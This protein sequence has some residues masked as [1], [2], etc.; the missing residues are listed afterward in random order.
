MPLLA[1]VPS[2]TSEGVCPDPDTCAWFKAW[3]ASQQAPEFAAASPESA[4][5][6]HM[7]H[8]AHVHLAQQPW[9]DASAIIRDYMVAVT[10]KDCCVMIA[11]QHTRPLPPCDC[12]VSA[13]AAALA[14][15]APGSAPNVPRTRE[16]EP[17]EP[18]L[19][20]AAA[21]AAGGTYAEQ[22]GALEARKRGALRAPGLARGGAILD[23]SDACRACQESMRRLKTAVEAGPPGCAG[24]PALSDSS[25]LGGGGASGDAQAAHTCCGRLDAGVASLV[26]RVGVVDFD[27]KPLAKVE[28]HLALD[29]AIEVAVGDF[30]GG[31]CSRPM[32]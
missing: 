11:L 30:L 13:A 26:Y 12:T 24:V 22:S 21:P 15:A 27:E 17:R 29:M 23:G 14:G 16:A 6:L 32:F 18:E 10:A 7:W 28:K 19:A 1:G 8:R 5:A 31:S 25:G 2:H 3:D 9:S 4:A 20:P